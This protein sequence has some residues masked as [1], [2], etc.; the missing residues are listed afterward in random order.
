MLNMF[1]SIPYPMIDPVIFSVGPV[2]IR[3]YSLAYIGGILIAWWLLRRIRTQSPVPVSKKDIDDVVIWCIVGVFVGGRLGYVLFYEPVYFLTHPLA[4]IGFGEG[5]NLFTDGLRGMSFHG[6][7]LGV[8]LALYFFS[9]NRMLPL[10]SLGDLIVSVAPIGLFFGRIANFINSELYGRVTEVPWGVVFPNGGPLPRHPSQL[11]EAF[12]EGIVLF[13]VLWAVR[14]Y[15]KAMQRPGIVTGVFLMGYALC[16]IVVEFFREPDAQIGI[17]FQG[18]TMGQWLSIPMFM[19][20]SLMIL[21][22]LFSGPLTPP[23]TPNLHMPP[24]KPLK[25]KV[26]KKTKNS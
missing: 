19:I 10:L 23:N 16:R 1:L 14:H 13:I 9:R 4:I 21:F 6:G 8:V 7:L 18:L 11:Y 22:A 25:K 15:T 26:T 20:G 2:A 12:F 3:W 17:L 5:S 24:P